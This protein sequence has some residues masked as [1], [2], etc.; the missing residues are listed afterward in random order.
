MAFQGDLGDN[1]SIAAG[2]EADLREALGR[3]NAR[4]R[5]TII[6]IRPFSGSDE[7]DISEWLIRWDVAANANNWTSAQQ[8]TMMP[9]YLMGRAGRIYWRLSA[10]VRNNL[11]DLKDCLD[12]HFNTQ[13]KRFLENKN[14]KK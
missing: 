4:P 13:E 8:L 2:E 6:D 3:D 1:E 9:A 10:E 14:F 11:D 5:R 7:E 12:E